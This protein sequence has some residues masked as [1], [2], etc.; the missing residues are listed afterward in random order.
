[1]DWLSFIS[2]LVGSL[3]WPLALVA[4]VWLLRGELRGLV[5]R[6]EKARY[7][8]AEL[9]FTQEV[10]QLHV[11]AAQQARTS[12]QDGESPV[13]GPAISSAVQLARVLDDHPRSVVLASWALVESA[14]QALARS[15][16]QAEL[17]E[18]IV[19]AEWPY[20][21]VYLLR[22]EKVLGEG[23]ALSLLKAWDVRQT[24]RTIEPPVEAAREYAE[25]S[26]L[27]VASLTE[28][29]RAPDC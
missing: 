1:M 21:L 22:D 12:D 10:A 28:I 23:L 25:T 5:R 15:R 26:D 20:K 2:N 6:M 29:R 14:L 27:L 9:T 3:A 8:G 17:A 18:R 16:G 19:Q 7:K 24:S 13:R 4:V 11:E